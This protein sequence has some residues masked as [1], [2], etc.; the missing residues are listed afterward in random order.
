[1]LLLSSAYR[2]YATNFQLVAELLLR[3]TGLLSLM[4]LQWHFA[5]DD[6]ILSS[7]QKE[8]PIEPVGL[9]KDACNAGLIASDPTDGCQEGTGRRTHL[10]RFNRGAVVNLLGCSKTKTLL[11]LIVVGIP[12]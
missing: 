1:M 3:S 12:M 7:E 4:F 2:V 6:S 11:C 8:L 5:V 9:P 10:C